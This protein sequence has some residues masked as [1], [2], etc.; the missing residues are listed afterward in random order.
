MSNCAI[1]R[2]RRG[3]KMLAAAIAGGSAILIAAPSAL[4]VNTD[5]WKVGSSNW[6]TATNW[7][8]SVVPSAGDT[9]NI[10]LSNTASFTVTYDFTATTVTLNTMTVNMSTASGTGTFSMSADTLVAT[11]ENVG[12]SGAG[13]NGSGTFNESGGLNSISNFGLFLGYNATDKGFYNLSSGALTVTNS[14]EIVGNNGTGIL[15]QSGGT[16]T[17][18]S[19]NNLY[20][21]FNSGSTGTYILSNGSLSAGATEIVG[22]SGTGLFNQSGGANTITG[23]SSLLYLGFN[24]DTTGT[25]TLSA[26][27]LSVAANEIVG[28]LGTGIFNQ[29]GGTNTI[30]N[31]SNLNIGNLSGSTGTYT[32]SGGAL[33]VALNELVGNGGV[34]IFNQSGGT[35]TITGPDNLYLGN[36]SG[37]TGTYTLSGTGSLVVTGGI[38]GEFVGLNG[39]GIFNQSGGTN[40]VSGGFNLDIAANGGSTG[41]YTLSGGLASV[42]G[43]VYVGGTAIEPGGAGVLTVGGA[44]V[45]NVSGTLTVYNTPGSSVT[46][47]GGTISTAQLDVD[48]VPSLFNWTSGTLKLTSGVTFDPTAGETSAAFGNSL[49]L[50][51]GQTLMVTGNETL[52]GAGGFAITL[53]SGSTHYVSGSL[54]VSPTGTITQNA[55][56]TL[57]ADDFVLAG[58]N[59]NGTLTNQ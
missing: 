44:G 39:K 28:H 48:G 6:D 19:G 12:D 42:S 14:S 18:G 56:S 17:T 35:N 29:T 27:S 32:L 9:V 7:S 2:G 26:G 20:L 3:P 11:T 50:G 16:S 46:L 33:S 31:S 30:S 47:S 41:T 57:Y 53:N 55:G 23:G 25:Y 40:I 13:S 4:A 5:N 8:S 45:L 51:S 22:D 36:S 38:G 54:T 21:G 58:G 37:S 49:T 43:G 34:G 1:V 52:G 59:V 24:G 15:N 10:G